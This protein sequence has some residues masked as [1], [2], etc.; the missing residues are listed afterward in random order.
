M[1]SSSLSILALATAMP[2]AAHA[3]GQSAVHLQEVVISGG[4]AP[5]EQARYGR[6]YSIVTAEAIERRGL[7]TISDVLRALPGVAV[8]ATGGNFTQVRIRGGEGNQTLVLVDGVRLPT[9]RDEYIFAG[10]DTADI[11]RVE[12]LRGPQSAFYGNNAASGVINIIT[13]KATGTG[14]GGKIE[15]GNGHLVNGYVQTRTDKGGLRFSVT[16]L[17]DRGYDFSGNDGEKDFTKRRTYRL[18]SDWLLTDKL[19]FGANFYHAREH[20]AFDDVDYV[21][22]TTH[23]TYLKDGPGVKTLRREN[24]GTLSL[25]YGTEADQLTHHLEASQARYQSRSLTGTWNKTRNDALKYRA[26]IGL[27]GSV[28]TASQ[29]LFLMLEGQKD[30]NSSNPLHERRQ[31]SL[32]FEYR[33]DFDNGLSLQ[34]GVRHDNNNRFDEFTGWNVAASY[35][36]N[37]TLRFHGSAGLALVKASYTEIYGADYGN[38][39]WNIDPNLGLLPEEDESI[40]FGVE[41][42]SLDGRGLID[43]TFFSERLTNEIGAPRG[44]IRSY[45]NIPGTGKRKGVEVQGSYDLTSQFTLGVN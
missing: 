4:L 25:S 40:D 12:V 5:I 28:G 15:A 32:A 17:H 38:P 18:S 20:Y 33:G 35:Q 30:K 31:H 1:R 41:Y 3:E 34:A 9:E 7:Q 26:T 21:N 44:T 23:E 16:D 22:G 11:E 29:R 14:Y 10:L 36:L 37:D 42:R 8:N 2:F 27:D 45:S 13:R 24:L 19:S 39:A 43:V 6:A